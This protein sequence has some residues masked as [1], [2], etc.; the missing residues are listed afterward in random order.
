MAIARAFCK[1]PAI[2]ILDEAT[3]SLDTA[4][5]AM[6]QSALKNL[7]QGRTS[8]VIAHRLVTVVDSDL[9]VV[10]DGGLIV[11]KGTHQELMART[12]GLYRSLCRSQFEVDE[13]ETVAAAARRTHSGATARSRTTSS[14]D[15]K[16]WT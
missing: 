4:N 16:Q 2:V 1:D 10:M 15:A 7:L 13:P 9:I 12:D 14:R 11:E 6:I 8:F 5:E 3:S